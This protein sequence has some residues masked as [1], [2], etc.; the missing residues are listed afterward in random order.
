M[1]LEVTLVAPSHV[2]SSPDLLYSESLVAADGIC[3][4]GL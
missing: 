4:C 2:C 3:S 1:P